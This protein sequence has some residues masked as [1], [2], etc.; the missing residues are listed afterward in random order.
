MK[1]A[2][3]KQRLILDAAIDR[4]VIRGTLT[5]PS[6]DRREFHGW[7]ELNTALEATL[8]ARAARAPG[9][10]PAASTAVPANARDPRPTQPVTKSVNPPAGRSGTQA[11]AAA[12]KEAHNAKLP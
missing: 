1:T 6:G 5:T 9:E 8:D 10:N 2:T 4:S 3:P 11:R 7:L 12:S